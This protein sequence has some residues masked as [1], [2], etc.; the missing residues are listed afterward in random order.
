MGEP[1]ENRRESVAAA[2]AMLRDEFGIAGAFARADQLAGLLGLSESAI[3]GQAQ[4]G[5]FPIPHRRV[6]KSILFKVESVAAWYC[7][8]DSTP[9]PIR[10][11]DPR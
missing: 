11:R 4:R 1:G 10:Q 7:L 6:G 5:T 2:R 8:D 9:L 3:R